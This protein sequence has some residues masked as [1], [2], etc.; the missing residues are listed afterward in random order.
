MAIKVND[1]VIPTWAIER[2]AQSLYEQVRKSM[3]GKPQE[4]IHLAAIDL[5]KERMI[6]QTLMGQE[7]VRRNYKIDPEE[8]NKGVTRWMRQNG[9]KKAIE[10]TNHPAIKD[11]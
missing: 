6:D 9:G 8:V 1:Q 10:K 11:R 2:Q 5:A 7:S 4:V 3:P